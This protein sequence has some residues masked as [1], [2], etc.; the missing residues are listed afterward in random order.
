[1][2]QCHYH[3]EISV[4]ICRDVLIFRFKRKPDSEKTLQTT[5]MVT[6][7]KNI[8]TQTIGSSNKRIIYR[9]CPNDTTRIYR[10][11]IVLVN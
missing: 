10:E 11:G 6:T 8:L 1:M 4:R 9:N 5:I 3:K 7:T 2:Q